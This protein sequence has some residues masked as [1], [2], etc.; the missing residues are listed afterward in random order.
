MLRDEARRAEKAIRSLLLEW[1]A[2]GG[3]PSDEYD[4]MI[5]PLYNLILRHCSSDEIAAWVGDYRCRVIGIEDDREA[6]LT[7]AQ[8]LRAAF[9]G[10]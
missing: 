5:W 8:H 7:L 3:V 10:H 1:D 6:N 4:G 2:I 9:T